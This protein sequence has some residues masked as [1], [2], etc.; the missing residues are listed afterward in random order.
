MLDIHLHKTRIGMGAKA[1]R[2]ERSEE[3]P[4]EIGAFGRDIDRPGNIPEAEANLAT[5]SGFKHFL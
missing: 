4:P 1:T 2:C 5:L 3:R